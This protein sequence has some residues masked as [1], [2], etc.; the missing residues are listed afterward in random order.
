MP[1]KMSFH[2]VVA[3]KSRARLLLLPL[4]ALNVMGAFLV[5]LVILS[6]VGPGGAT[7]AFMAAA[8]LPQMLGGL[9][10]AALASALVPM[11]AGESSQQQCG[12]A[13][14]LL[15]AVGA[16]FI[17][18]ALPLSL[19]AELWAGWLFPGFPADVAR[20]CADLARIQVFSIAFSAMSSVLVAVCY[21]RGQFVRVEFA[22][23]VI[24][25]T[26]AATLYFALPV[27][28]ITAA[29]WMVILTTFCQML[30][31][32]PVVGRP[33]R[34]SITASRAAGF[35]TRVR[36]L[37]LGNIY[38]KS[39]VVVDR[40]LLSMA[41]AGELTLFALAQQFHGAVAGILGKVWGNTAIPELAVF[42]KRS[43]LPNFVRLYNRRLVILALTSG[44]T[45][46]LLWL[47]GQEALA[48]LLGHGK[49]SEVNI[50][51]LWEIMLASAGVLMFACVGVIVAG[52]YYAM[53]DTR[54]PTY[55]SM[56][57]FSVFV[58]VKYFAFHLFGAIGVAL[59]ASCYFAL[60][61][62]LLGSA[63]SFKLRRELE[64]Q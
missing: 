10:W 33:Q 1:R 32:L 28:G 46:I 53:G 59:A 48:L 4:A 8:T 17:G 24:A 60:T 27:Y 22:T 52:A 47:V 62:I 12:D 55:L 2:S 30:L 11:F 35:W 16:I 37:L 36:P 45:I 49:M 31:L 14:F 42:A 43:D 64:V 63:L 29:S 18:A 57:S 5:Q 40:F 44:V 54:T 19:T 41:G 61:A 58:V 15:L 38:H 51:T 7:D 26:S 13:W 6:R 50:V 23:L 9:A 21:A 20:L 56:A 25:G 3:T 39:D 34:L